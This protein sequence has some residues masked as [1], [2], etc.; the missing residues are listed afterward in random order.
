M[1]P[2]YDYQ[3]SKFGGKFVPPPPKADMDQF[4]DT[5]QPLR[6]AIRKLHDVIE[7]T[8]LHRY[9]AVTSLL[10]KNNTNVFD[11]VAFLNKF[12]QAFTESIRRNFPDINSVTLDILSEKF[13]E[14][15]KH[16]TTVLK[17]TNVENRFLLVLVTAMLDSL[18]A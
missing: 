6:E 1:K 13:V 10:F 3:P 16:L 14:S 9:R 11:S 12:N 18:L 2:D 4:I 5:L 15:E 8:D 17:K 7:N